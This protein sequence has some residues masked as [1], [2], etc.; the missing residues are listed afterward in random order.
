MTDQDNNDE[1]A[2]LRAAV[3]I[4]RRIVCKRWAALG[5][6]V[7]FDE[8]MRAA[9][10]A[11]GAFLEAEAR[12]P[13]APMRSEGGSSTFERDVARHLETLLEARFGRE[14]TSEAASHAAALLQCSVGRR[15]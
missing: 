10:A 12:A 9:L 1:H 11:L 5:C 3:A 13:R 2:R 8:L 6:S 15:D 7:D 14:L 4:S